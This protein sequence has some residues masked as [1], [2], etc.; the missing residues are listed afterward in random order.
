[1]MGSDMGDAGKG[2][3]DP[4]GVE[5]EQ[6]DSY[7]LKICKVMRIALVAFPL[8]MASLILFAWLNNQ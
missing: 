7:T 3:P 1:M 2:S 6:E 4:M 5:L 8:L